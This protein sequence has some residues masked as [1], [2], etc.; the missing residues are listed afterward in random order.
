MGSRWGR[1]PLIQVLTWLV[2]EG[3]VSRS[4][5]TLVLTRTHG[6]SEGISFLDCSQL[7]KAAARKISFISHAFWRLLFLFHSIKKSLLASTW[8]RTLQRENSANQS[9]SNTELSSAWKK[10]I[11]RCQQME[12]FL[13]MDHDVNFSTQ[14]WRSSNHQTKSLSFPSHFMNLYIF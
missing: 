10:A 4:Y 8:T 5:C 7:E 9:A 3:K 12:M 6:G 11:W 1:P 13:M 14:L 2:F